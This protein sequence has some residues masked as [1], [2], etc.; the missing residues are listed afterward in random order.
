M[1]SPDW[2]RM[3]ARHNAWQNDWMV[4]AILSL[5]DDVLQQDRGLFFGSILASANHLLWGD[6]AWLHRFGAGPMPDIPPARNTELTPD[7]ASWA[8]AR[9][10]T[11]AALLDWTDGLETTAGDLIWKSALS[12]RE[13]VTPVAVAV[14]HLFIHQV[15]HRGQLH[16]A[17][18]GLGVETGVTDLP[19]GPQFG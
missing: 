18:T 8:A 2:A 9:R 19:Y 1:I 14:T 6:R 7:A 3:M 12:D 10:E 17:L 16:A 13:N 5:D 11:D 15:H 4:A